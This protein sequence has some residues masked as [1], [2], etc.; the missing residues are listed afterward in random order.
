MWHTDKLKQMKGKLWIIPLSLLA[1]SGYNQALADTSF[2]H[3]RLSLEIADAQ[4]NVS[5]VVRDVNTGAPIP[6]VTITVKGTSQATQTDESGRY[7]IQAN[8]GQVLV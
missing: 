5:G 4:L 2:T 6:G 1:A 3:P 8:T 7:S